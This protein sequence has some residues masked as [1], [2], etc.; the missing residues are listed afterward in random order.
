MTKGILV[1]EVIPFKN[2]KEKI[3]ITKEYEK[4]KVE[5]FNNYIIVWMNERGWKIMARWKK[6][7]EAEKFIKDNYKRF[8]KKEDI[9][10][11]LLKNFDF[12]Y[13]IRL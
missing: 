11:E 9:I 8:P 6:I 1:A 3:R 7:I 2:F 4:F 13:N 10:K 12:S 5:V